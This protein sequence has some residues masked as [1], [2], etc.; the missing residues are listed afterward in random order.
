MKLF[1]YEFASARAEANLP[2]SIRTEGR[3]MLGALKADA[4]RLAGVEVLV[5][6]PAEHKREAAAFLTLLRQADACLVIAPE[7][8]RRLEERAEWVEAARRR[9]D[10][11]G[12]YLG[13]T[14]EAVAAVSDKYT[15]AVR[16]RQ[17]GV[18][19][20][21]TWRPGEAPRAPP[22]W[23]C[24]L[25][26]GAG[27]QDM[28]LVTGPPTAATAADHDRIFQEYCPGLAVSLAFLCG[29]AGFRMPLLPAVQCLSTDGAFRYLGGSL[30]APLHLWERIT[31]LATRALEDT[32]GL[33]GFVGID[34]VMGEADDGTRD[35]VIE[36]NPRLTTSYIGLRR[37]TES[38]LLELL[39]KIVLGQFPQ[40]PA[41]LPK[42]VRFASDGAAMTE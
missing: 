21:R 31:S 35:R 29:P 2:E 25:R 41:W 40:P 27:S 14:P 33:A 42:T 24:K 9:G 7:L 23:V 13:C 8:H 15:Q 18:P 37:A 39:L 19:T 1:L 26:V 28:C 22:P 3:A 11:S 32:P 10:F 17:R 36:I 20:A 16:W 12:A 6:Q 30:P 5:L 34:L 4:L 38:N